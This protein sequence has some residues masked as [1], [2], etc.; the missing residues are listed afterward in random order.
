MTGGMTTVFVTGA[1]A[2]C[3][4]GA[5]RA[6]RMSGYPARVVTGD[7]DPRAAGHWLGD[8]AYTIPMATDPSYLPRLEE[9]IVREGVSILLVGTDVE[10]AVLSRARPRLEA[11]YGVRVAVSSPEVIDIAD[12]KWLTAQF[13]AESGFPSP[14]SAL[15]ADREAVGRLVAAA[16]FPLFAKPRRGARSVGAAVVPDETALRALLERPG[17]MLVQELLPAH[18]GEYTAGCIIIGGRC[19]ATVALRRDLRDGNT[20][21]AYSEGPTGFEDTITRIATALGARGAD[22]PCNFQF[23]VKDGRP[24][25][26]EIN[27]RFS[28]T[29]PLR[30]IFG[31]NGVEAVV[32]YL[33]EGRL[34]PPPQIR[35]G[36]VLR[37]WS[38]V[39][40]EAD[41]L[42]A[43]TTAGRLPQPACEQVPF[44]PPLSEV[45]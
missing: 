38:D 20:Y 8:C 29:T 30:A 34:V 24:V 9:V 41:Q 16:G 39:L 27:A 28:G 43:L 44:A 2:L 23:R 5:L 14:M 13:L 21:R 36:V 6:L 1:G 19:T 25:V 22:G 37:V 15:A 45:G 12:D 32:A 42:D 3:G 17:D 40:V 10:L 31:F 4:Q 35:R 7:P 26:F 11:Q 33:A 18:P